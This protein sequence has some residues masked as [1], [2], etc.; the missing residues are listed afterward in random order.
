MYYVLCSLDTDCGNGNQSFCLTL[1]IPKET[2]WTYPSLAG[3]DSSAPCLCIHPIACPYRAFQPLPCSNPDLLRAFWFHRD[4]WD[5][6]AQNP[7]LCS[8]PLLSRWYC[9][10]WE[11]RHLLMPSN[12]ELRISNGTNNFCFTGARWSRQNCWHFTKEAVRSK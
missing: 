5:L 10:L 12:Q 7:K 6:R 8:L 4:L 9:L 1:S 2:W 11:K 3:L